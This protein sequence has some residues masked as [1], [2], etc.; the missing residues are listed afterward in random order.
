MIDCEFET[1][2]GECYGVNIRHFRQVILRSRN[3]STAAHLRARVRAPYTADAY[4]DAVVRTDDLYVVSMGN[5]NGEFF[6][7][8]HT[9]PKLVTN[10]TLLGFTGHYNDLGSYGALTLDAATIDNAIGN[11]SRRR[12]TDRLTSRVKDRYGEHQ[13]TPE[14]GYLLTLI[15]MASEGARFYDVEKTVANAL[16]GQ[17]NT[18]LD[19]AAIATLVHEWEARSRQNDFRIVAI[20]KT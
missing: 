14:A 11:I 6:F 3:Q 20:P 18:P 15:L 4:V 13:T 7:K 12:S 10:Q 16:D 9:G 5:R 1:R 17:P 8:D 2:T 19:P